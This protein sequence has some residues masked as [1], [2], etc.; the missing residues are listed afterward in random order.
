METKE[1]IQAYIDRSRSAQQIFATYSQEKVDEAVRAVGKIIYDNAEELAQ[2]AIDET[3]YGV[4]KDKVAKNKGKSKA[5]WFKLKGVKSRGIIRYV[6][7]E[8]IVEI[9]KPIGVIGCV[10]PTTNPTMTPMHNAM[11][12]LKGGNSLIISPHPRAKKTGIKTVEY[13]RK[14]LE[15][16]GA[17]VDLIQVIPD[18][19]LD[20]SSMLMSMCD[21][22]ISTGGKIMVHAAF[23]SGK[24]AFGVGA[25]N[26]Q[27]LIDRD[28]ELKDVVPMM[29]QGRTYDNGVLCTCD[30]AAICPQEEYDEMIKLMKDSN[31]Y[32]VE[33]EE[34]ISKLRKLM[35]GTGSLNKDVIGI[36]AARIAGMAGIK[37][38][39][40]TR[41]LLVRAEK[42]GKDELLAKEKLCPVQLAY[43]YDKW[44]DAVAIANAN[45]WNDGTGH[46]SVLHSN[47]KEHIEYAALILP[48]S[49]F[50][51]NQQGSSSLGGTMQNGLMPTATL[52]CGSWGNNSISENLWWNHL[53]NISRIAYVI[54]ERKIP[55]DDEIW[56]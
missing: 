9:S 26:I 50:A 41:M 13:M 24:P 7:D 1:M 56:G 16:I 20:T 33:S 31:V 18:S 12:A 22:C 5:T 52:G 37:V 29:I 34:E 39:D 27:D 30:Q 10:P 4:Y 6:E 11:I 49:R 43:K 47:T 42:Y 32:Y 14:A 46:S 53:V 36:S 23:S 38:P 51:V 15:N 40:D 21:T 2:L 19:D 55:T 28:V 35:F 48:V 54:P 17:P 45:L 25:G 3:K 44:E 8:G